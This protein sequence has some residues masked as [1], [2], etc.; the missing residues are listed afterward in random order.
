MFTG[1]EYRRDE[2][3]TGYPESRGSSGRPMLPRG[4]LLP[5]QAHVETTPYS[6][7]IRL[8]VRA[9]HVSVDK[10]PVVV[11]EVLVHTAQ[12]DDS[13]RLEDTVRREQLRVETEGDVDVTERRAR[14]PGVLW[15][16]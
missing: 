5:L 1:D 2:V 6:C 10:R 7:T 9:E 15:E 4:S 8:P 16:R 3:A 11:E 13:V 14:E 12:V